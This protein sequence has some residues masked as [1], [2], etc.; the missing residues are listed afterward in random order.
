MYCDLAYEEINSRGSSCTSGTIG[1]PD[2]LSV[3]DIDLEIETSEPFSMRVFY[4]ELPTWQLLESI[5]A[6]VPWTTW[7]SSGSLRESPHLPWWSR[8]SAVMEILGSRFSVDAWHEIP[9]ITGWCHKYMHLLPWQQVDV[10]VH[11]TRPA[12][13]KNLTIY[14]FSLPHLQSDL[15]VAQNWK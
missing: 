3:C 7:K 12:L 5:L 15:G 14:L 1:V 9:K 10:A 4:T 6:W 8:A 2:L 11:I 13:Q